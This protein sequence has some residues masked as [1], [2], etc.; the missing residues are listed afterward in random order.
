MKKWGLIGVILFL[1]TLSLYLL[2]SYNIKELLTNIRQIID[3][4]ELLIICNLVFFGVCAYNFIKRNYRKTLPRVYILFILVI[5]IN[6]FF[7]WYYKNFVYA[8]LPF[9]IVIYDLFKTRVVT[10]G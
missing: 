8:N 3:S 1:Y 4:R 6:I 5:F 7:G 9:L 2:V 10:K